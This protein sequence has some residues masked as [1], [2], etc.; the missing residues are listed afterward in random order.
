MKMGGCE[1][2]F[3][4][5]K[6][7]KKCTC[8]LCSHFSMKMGGCEGLFSDFKM[9]KK[10]TCFLCSDSKNKQRHVSVCVRPCYYFQK[11]ENL[12]STPS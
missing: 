8:F 1:G 10:C 9:Q 4:D 11:V 5:F 3:S 6:M 7:Q 2:L 12:L